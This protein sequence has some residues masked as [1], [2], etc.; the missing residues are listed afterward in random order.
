MVGV[1]KLVWLLRSLYRRT[2][3]TKR[4]RRDRAMVRRVSGLRKRRWGSYLGGVG[5][6]DVG[7]GSFCGDGGGK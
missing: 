7:G 6:G 4:W 5:G 3:R 2:I 1:V